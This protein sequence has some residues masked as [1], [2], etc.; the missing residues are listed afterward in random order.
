MV[1]EQTFGYPEKSIV[2]KKNMGIPRKG[3]SQG[4]NIDTQERQ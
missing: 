4:T 3:H 1:T 2:I